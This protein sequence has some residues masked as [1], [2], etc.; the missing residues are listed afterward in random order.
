MVKGSSETQCQTCKLA[1]L[2]ADQV[3]LQAPGLSEGR[4]VTEQWVH[5][6]LRPSVSTVLSPC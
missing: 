6:F 4:A 3:R 1:A 5:S 2:L